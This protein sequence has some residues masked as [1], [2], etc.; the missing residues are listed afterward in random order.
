MTGSFYHDT[1][2]VLSQLSNYCERDK[3]LEATIWSFFR[4]F[5]KH[6]LE[7]VEQR[8]PANPVGLENSEFI[9]SMGAHN[10]DARDVRK[11]AAGEIRK[12]KDDRK[13]AKKAAQLA[14]HRYF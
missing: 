12:Q 1:T 10:T 9:D 7:A 8:F 6:S 4:T 2:A 3:K 5:Q 11:R 13:R 14:R